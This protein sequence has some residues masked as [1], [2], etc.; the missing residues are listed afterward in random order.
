MQKYI[1]RTLF[2][3]YLH[4]RHMLLSFLCF[5]W[6]TGIFT[7]IPSF[8]ALAANR[9]YHA[10]EYGVNGIDKKDDTAAIQYL[11]D[12]ANPEDHITI[13][14]PKGTY[15]IS[16]TLLIQSNTTLQLHP[17]AVICR[18]KDG[19]SKNML[20]TVDSKKNSGRIGKYNLAK[21]ITI[22]GGT[23]HGGNISLSKK[24][25]NLIYIGH[26]QNIVIRDATI[27][28]YH[29]SH[30]IE[31]AGVKN[32]T[33]KNCKFTGFRYDQRKFASE[34][35]QIDVCH[36]IGDVHWT[37]GFKADKTPCK[38]IKIYNNTFIDC[39]RAVGSHNVLRGHYSK[40]IIIAN[41]K[42]KRSSPSMQSKAV[43]GIYLMGTSDVIVRDNTIEG[44]S[45]GLIAKSNK[46]LHIFKNTFK[47]C[48]MIPYSISGSGKSNGTR[49]FVIEN[50]DQET[51]ELEIACP[52]FQKI[53]MTIKGK[54]YT[55]NVK[56]GIAKCTLKS[57]IRN[58]E[59]ASFYAKDSNGNKVYKNRWIQPRA[60]QE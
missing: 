19:I 53:K 3:L 48:T 37:S 30:A 51:N 40:N 22:Q 12:M 36:K 29:G 46:N 57:S 33:V 49:N 11:L 43:T 25:C 32:A 55:I 60:T 10:E 42:I 16:K 39:P 17:Q 23:W 52:G 1:V 27:K 14:F 47:Y 54:S 13:V 8:H 7:L 15:Y 28:N 45:Y 26:S 58:G 24:N 41:N 21:N 34:A 9:T 2:T 5:I 18:S 50:F 4:K 31:F 35:I 44:Y 20:R 56:D 59:K 6:I 38:N